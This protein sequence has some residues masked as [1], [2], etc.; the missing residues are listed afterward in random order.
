M[1]MA[2]MFQYLLGNAEI[3]VKMKLLLTFPL[4]DSYYHAII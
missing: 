3:C 4:N 2:V 1:Y